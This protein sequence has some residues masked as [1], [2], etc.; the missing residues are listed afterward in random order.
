MPTGPPSA[1]RSRA[2]AAAAAANAVSLPLAG[3]GS[4]A[5]ASVDRLT[6]SHDALAGP[7]RAPSTMSGLADSEPA[8]GASADGD[9][10]CGAPASAASSRRPP[11]P[12]TPSPRTAA[13]IAAALLAGGADF[14]AAFAAASDERQRCLERE[15][16][17]AVTLQAA[18]RGFIL[19]RALKRLH[20]L[21]FRIQRLWRSHAARIR[22]AVQAT[23]CAQH[24]EFMRRTRAAVKIQAAWRGYATRQLRGHSM[25]TR[26]RTRLFLQQQN[27]RMLAQLDQIA[28]A[29]Q[30][31]RAAMVVQKQAYLLQLAA[32]QNHHLVSTVH[33]PGVFAEVLEPAIR[34]EGAALPTAASTCSIDISEAHVLTGEKP[35]LSRPTTPTRLLNGYHVRL[36]DAQLWNTAELRAYVTASMA[37]TRAAASALA[38]PRSSTP[39]ATTFLASPPAPAP[40]AAPAGSPRRRAAPLATATSSFKATPRRSHAF[41]PDTP[42]SVLHTPARHASAGRPLSRYAASALASAGVKAKRGM[43]AAL[44]LRPPLPRP[45]GA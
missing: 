38:P 6:A 42:P 33:I 45:Q 11:S 27:E 9:A 39:T 30:Q 29:E 34:P 7:P 12:H 8:R 32:V 23:Q 3:G 5:R 2:A 31:E 14:F 16:T 35:S 20:W 25:A 15:W 26:R 17:A 36:T 41:F 22:T 24:R 13:P 40:P 44:P 10:L 18:A 28:G 1:G 4:S 37:R 19:R 43:V 21:A